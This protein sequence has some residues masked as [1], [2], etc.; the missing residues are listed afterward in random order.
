MQKKIILAFAVSIAGLGMAQEAPNETMPVTA[1]QAEA[2]EVTTADQ[3]PAA[4][5][6]PVSTL[7]GTGQTIEPAVSAAPNQTEQSQTPIVPEQIQSPAAS[8]QSEEP[9][10]QAVSQ[11]TAQPVSQPEARATVAEPQPAPVS[12]SQE[13]AP[14]VPEKQPEQ[15]VT[16]PAPAV[17]SAQPEEPVEHAEELEI[18]GIDTIDIT[19]H[20]G[21][22]LYKRIWWEKAERTYEK[23][24]QL[25]E[26][27]Q[28][29]RIIFFA[30]RTDL[31]R[32]TLDPFY[33]GQGFSQGELTE[34]INFL[35]TRLEEERR[36]GALD[37]KE[38]ALL[39]VL[40]EEKKNLEVL[41]KGVG[42]IS[43]I[44]LALDDAL[45]KLSEQLQQARNY[46]HQ[47]WENFKAI[48]RELSDKRARE[49]Y[50]GM[51]TYWRNLNNIN[52][53]ISDAYSQYFDQLTDRLKQEIDKIKST[54]D[55]LKE[56]GVDIQLQA[57][58]LKTGKPT[59]L[60][61]ESEPT[62]AEPTGVF[63]TLWNWLKA[64][65][66][67]IADMIS[68]AVGWITGTGATE[69]LTL[70]RPERSQSE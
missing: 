9:S 55:V 23:I 2:P 36:E 69:E 34:I 45:L 33:L 63:N 19:E 12:V 62:A 24:K 11:D 41:Q 50:Y 67:A 8:E 22:W 61:E 18:K 64:P 29:A 10:S 32:N 27:I 51:D 43:N 56:K 48:N 40:S 5:T 52:T 35:T 47:A 57:Q 58:R 42:A 53:Y 3:S 7:N 28:E 60:E 65:F 30:R 15:P 6:E 14:A 38:Q 66:I 25:A 1:E 26:K 21:N 44:D 37:E 16:Q 31:D 17:Q 4:V 59:E 49:L 70:A 39:N 46:E 68:G 54:M 13:Q 20:K